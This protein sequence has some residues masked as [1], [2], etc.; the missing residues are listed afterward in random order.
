MSATSVTHV[1]TDC[2]LCGTPLPGVPVIH[3]QNVPAR[4]QNFLTQD[5]LDKDS[6]TE[7]K[8]FQCFGCGHVQ[9]AS[10]PVVYT[11]GV[12]STTAYSQ[13]ML[14]YRQGQLRDFIAQHHLAGKTLLDVGCGDGH[15]LKA[16][17]EEGVQ[18]V[19]VDASEKALEIARQHG[20]K[21]YF[22][23]ITR[24][25]QI[26]DGPFDGFVCYDVI[27]HVP[28]LKD[29][30]QGICA[31]LK[32]GA[33]GLLETP[34]FE[35]V[36]ETQ[37]FYDF[38][39]D[40]LSYFTVQTLRL[41]ME[42]SGFNVLHI[43]RNRDAENLTVIV[44]KRDTPAFELLASQSDTLKHTLT[45]FF[46]DMHAQGKRIAIWGASLQ[47]LTLSSIMPLDQIAYIIDSA[48][49]KQGMY[50]PVSH[51]P[52]VSPAHLKAE[53]VDVIIVNAPRYQD[54]IIRQILTVEQFGGIVTVLNGTEIKI[55]HP[56]EQP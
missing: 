49:Y 40:H 35:K 38:M 39:Q 16:L 15:L 18:A 44:Q 24:H 42:L 21:V 7:L 43:E 30:L 10:Q 23:Y 32:P 36:L 41:A 27:E 33:V 54:E 25:H 52:I 28:D 1:R 48:T 17:K 51:L 53:P 37:R 50:T 45:A 19:G 34:S 5:Q 4:I 14:N 6:G 9:L 56:D 13:A 20:H 47:T 22:G 55:V 46:N 31:N 26:Q 11:Q 2:M 29:F 3:L 8:A 12:T